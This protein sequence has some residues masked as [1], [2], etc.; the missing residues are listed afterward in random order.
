MSDFKVP[1][2]TEGLSVHSDKAPE[3]VTAY[4][5]VEMHSR[6]ESMRT[7]LL[8]NHQ[9]KASKTTLVQAALQFMLEDYRLNGTE[10]WI[11]LRLATLQRMKGGQPC[12]SSTATATIAL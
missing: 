12:E 2:L 7:D 3:K 9:L 10:S 11:F 5:T 8:V 1:G 4:L 6:V